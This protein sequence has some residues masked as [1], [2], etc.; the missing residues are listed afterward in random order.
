MSDGKFSKWWPCLRKHYKRVN[1]W[2]PKAQM[3]RDSLKNARSFRYFTLCARPMI[4][5]YMLVRENVLPFDTAAKRILGVSFCECDERI[6]PEMKELIGAEE[7]GFLARLEEL[8]LFRDIPQT[9]T[10]DNVG[11]LFSFLEEEGEGLDPAVR[12]AL[13]D[14]RKHLLF[15][16]L[17]PF[18]FLN[19][20]FCD[21]YYGDPP[22][23]MKIHATLDKLLEWQRQPGTT[24]SGDNFSVSRFVVAI[25]CR[26][27]LST[28]RDAIRRLRHIVE[29]NRADHD[30]Y[31][32]A[33]ADK[34]VTDM[35]AWAREAPL[36]FFMSAWPK[37]IAKLAMQKAWDIIV[38]D[39]A[40]YG[41]ENDEGEKYDMVCLV[42][43]FVN[44]PLCTTYLKAV[45]WCLDERS[46]TAIPR[47]DE[48]AGKGKS[49]LLNLRQ[50]VEL[51]NEQARNFERPILP[52]PLSEIVR[53]RREGVPI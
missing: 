5:V 51:R 17:F 29:Q 16:G 21:R 36:D 13:E 14:K 40:F 25:T 34:P 41:R 9:E 52:D 6:F 38:H 4:D 26:V 46:R 49:L 39:H 48:T 50:I 28:P 27:D 44:A 1:L 18:D 22:D 23:V 32:Q 11:A 24:G 31:R 8:V 33:L 53:L 37:E 35:A 15:R 10:L 47:F 42:V 45:K 3:L 20:D 43:E 30:E 12:K 7:A 19:L 2:L